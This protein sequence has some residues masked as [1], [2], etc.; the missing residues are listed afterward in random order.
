MSYAKSFMSWASGAR[1]VRAAALVLPLLMLAG[2]DVAAQPRIAY[3][4]SWRIIG[5]EAEFQGS[6][7][8]EQALNRDVESWNRELE[9]RKQ[10][11]I[12]L[13]KEIEQKRLVVSESKRQELERDRTQKAGEYERRAKEVYGEGG[14][15]EKRNLELTRAILDKV[16]EAVT[17]IAREEGYDFVF[18]A[19]DANLVWANKDYDITDRVL[20]KLAEGLPAAAGTPAPGS[21]PAPPPQTPPPTTPPPR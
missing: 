8:A 2:G 10:A 11:I 7:D 18:D 14:L 3:V 16:K 15:I 6:R 5:P 17:L 20:A 19:S 13:E 21:T 4:T 1:I 9:E 12:G